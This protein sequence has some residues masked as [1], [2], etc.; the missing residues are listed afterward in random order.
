LPA[1]S[2]AYVSVQFTA[3][4]AVYAARRVQVEAAGA[5]ELVVDRCDVAVGSVGVG[6]VLE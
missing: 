3:C 2:Y 4:T 6:A 1:S 5:G